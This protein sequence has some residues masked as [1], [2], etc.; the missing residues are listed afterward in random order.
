MIK[1][2]VVSADIYL[3]V[4]QWA[5]QNNFVLPEKEFFARL[6]DEFS[7]CMRQIFKNFEI[8]SEDEMSQGLSDLVVEGGLP[9]VSLDRTYFEGDFR[10]ELTR[11]VNEDG[12][13]RCLGRRDGTPPLS[14]QIKRIQKSGEH[15][16]AL[17]D[18]V[19]FTGSLIRLIIKLLSRIN[20]RV[21]LVYAGIGIGNGVNDIS[22]VQNEVRCVR[23]YEDV[24]DEV[25][26]RDFYPGVPLS[27]RQLVGG[28]N[29]GIPYILP[30]GNPGEWASI[31]TEHSVS[32]SRFCLHQT[33][34][35]FDEIERCSD[36]RVY[37]RDLGR[38]VHGLDSDGTRYTDALRKIL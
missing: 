33:I 5:I 2:Y 7:I 38:K 37:C 22:G 20:V 30:F 15:E 19:I 31:P 6:R 29:V 10:I 35:L 18:D 16:V 27:G 23:V 4:K 32:F 28:R 1:P 17:V 21:P 25:C 13:N 34:L 14:Q 8:V 36:K 9:V 3:L 24:V 26:E 11:L 12:T